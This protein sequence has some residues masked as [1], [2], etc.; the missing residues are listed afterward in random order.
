VVASLDDPK[1]T[2]SIRLADLTVEDDRL[3][4]VHYLAHAYT[5]AVFS[6]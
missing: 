3:E 6:R 4:G 2:I 1:G 5:T